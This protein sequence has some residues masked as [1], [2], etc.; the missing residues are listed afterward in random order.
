MPLMREISRY[1]QPKIRVK[2]IKKNFFFTRGRIFDSVDDL[3]VQPAFATGGCCSCGGCFLP[4]TK[5]L[6]SDRSYKEI[7]KVKPGDITVSY[8]LKKGVLVKNRVVEKL[9]HPDYP[10]GYFLING[11]LKVTGNHRV[12][13]SNKA[14]WERVD[15]IKVDDVLLN[16]EG[17]D[18]VV[19]SIE[20]FDG[21][22]NVFNLH[23]AGDNHNYFAENYL[24]HNQK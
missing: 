12:F 4:G 6:M 22:N 16:E 7:E 19:E 2:K 20:Q 3:L 18:T 8:D 15:S 13:L 21:N 17:Q 9:I 14:K 11:T 23:M 5:I 24:V 1:Q 10:G